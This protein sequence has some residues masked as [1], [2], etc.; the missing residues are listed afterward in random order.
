MP[1]DILVG[2]PPEE[3][4]LTNNPH[5]FLE[6][7]YRDVE[8]SYA[9]ARRKLQ[10]CALRRKRYYD[11]KVKEKQFNVNEWV[12][13]FY[14][15]HYK[16]KSLKWQKA[17]IGPFLVVKFIPPSSCVLQ[18]TQKSKPFVVHVDKFKR[19]LGPTP[20]SWLSASL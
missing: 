7:L 10:S 5:E 12:Y 8:Y 3:S 14:P 4:G 18:K 17:Y 6:K 16:A 11:I 2:L 9:V 19:C 15:R 20:A 1:L 13:Y